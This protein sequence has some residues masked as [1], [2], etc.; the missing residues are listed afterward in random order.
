MNNQTE[1]LV[2]ESGVEILVDYEYEVGES[3]RE[4]CH[5]I[6]EVGNLTYVNILS[7]D[8]V[9]ANQPIPILHLLN[10]KQIEAIIDQLSC[11]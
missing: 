6:H 9:I 3:Q 8:M 1:M 11:Y 2:C 7:M 5:G 10:E 4:E